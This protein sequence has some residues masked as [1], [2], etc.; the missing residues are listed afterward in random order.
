MNLMSCG[1]SGFLSVIE[2]RRPA[3]CGLVCVFG[4]KVFNSKLTVL[5][6]TLSCCGGVGILCFTGVPNT[7]FVFCVIF[8][9]VISI[10]KLGR[11]SVRNCVVPG[12]RKGVVKRVILVLLVFKL[13]VNVVRE[14]VG[15]CR[16]VWR[17]GFR[18]WY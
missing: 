14:G 3:L 5:T 6:C 16:I 12:I 7:L 8:G 1:T 2:L 11:F 15:G 9:L 4:C 13:D 18:Y 10:F 17:G